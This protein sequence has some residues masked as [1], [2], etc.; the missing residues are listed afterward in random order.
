MNK[1]FFLIKNKNYKLSNST[2]KKTIILYKFVFNR[3][4]IPKICVNLEHDLFFYPNSLIFTMKDSDKAK[5]FSKENNIFF[6]YQL[7]YNDYDF[8]ISKSDKRFRDR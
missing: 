8:Y 1:L 5:L 7:E 2:I 4:I 3:L 6:R